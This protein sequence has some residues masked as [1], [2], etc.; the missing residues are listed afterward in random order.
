MLVRTQWNKYIFVC[1]CEWYC[2]KKRNL[3]SMSTKTQQKSWCGKTN[4]FLWTRYPGN[5][6]K[7]QG[8][9][10]KDIVDNER[11][12]E[13]TNEFFNSSQL[14][15]FLALTTIISKT[16]W[17]SVKEFPKYASK[18]F[19]RRIVARMENRYSMVNE[20]TSTF[21]FDILH[22][23]HLRFHAILSCG[24]HWQTMQIGTMAKPCF[25]PQNLLTW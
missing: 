8:A 14:Y 3:D 10:S 11:Y 24:K 6:L 2:L 17:K 25:V 21:S 13:L 12:S 19:T 9:I 15:H 7:R 5:L 4:N 23:S 1:S 18:F 20:Q 16:N 22:S